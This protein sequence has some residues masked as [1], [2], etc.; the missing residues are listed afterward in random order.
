MRLDRYLIDTIDR[1]LIC[2]PNRTKGL[3]YFIDA[4]FA[5]E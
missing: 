1:G 2:K 3:E 5:E 4:D